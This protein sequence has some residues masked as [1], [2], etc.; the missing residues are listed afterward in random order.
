MS[1]RARSTPH[2]IA[3]PSRFVIRRWPARRWGLLAACKIVPH[4]RADRRREVARGCG[5]HQL[6]SAATFGSAATRA[7]RVLRFQVS[8]VKG[9]VTKAVL[10]CYVANGSTMA[11]PLPRQH[12][13][14]GVRVTLGN[15]AA[16][17]ARPWHE[18]ASRANMVEFDVSS[19]VKGN[20][21]Y[22]FVLRAD[23]T[24]SVECRSRE[25]ASNRPELIVTRRSER[26]DAPRLHA[27]PGDASSMVRSTR[28]SGAVPQHYGDGNKELQCLTRTTST[29]ETARSTSWHERENVTCPNARSGASPPAS[30]ARAKR[31]FI[32]R[33]SRVTK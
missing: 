7:Q 8:G 6:R 2:V 26:T 23:S 29:R 21:S 16:R 24:D 28:K 5:G 11:R 12:R 18:A 32:S 9:A 1:P 4:V 17:L 22:D 27:V 13:V 30:S 3:I 19:V 31:A 25:A 20:G 15:S 10:R 33:A 14:D